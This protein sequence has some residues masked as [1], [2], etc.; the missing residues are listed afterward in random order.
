[1]SEVSEVS[2][3]DET[4]VGDNPANV[5]IPSDSGREAFEEAP[6]IV[7]KK[8]YD[9]SFLD[10]LEDLENVSPVAAVKGRTI[11]LFYL[12]NLFNR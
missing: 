1:V 8:G 10:K 2:A 7:P 9:L 4:I 5:S 11:K 12:L 3:Q 6:L